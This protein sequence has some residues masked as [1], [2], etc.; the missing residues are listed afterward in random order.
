[1]NNSF[2]MLFSGVGLALLDLIGYFLLGQTHLNQISY[3]NGM[4]ITILIYLIQPF[5]MYKVLQMGGT[6]TIL[7]LSWDCISSILVTLLG[8]FYFRDKVNG[9]KIYGVAFSILAIFLFAMDDYKA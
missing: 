2:L 4:T 8:I 7:N 1:M 5:I 3:F 9:L 6:V